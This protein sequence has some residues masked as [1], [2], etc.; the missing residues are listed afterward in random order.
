[1]QCATYLKKG[2]F[3]FRILLFRYMFT[4]LHSLVC[5]FLYVLCCNDRITKTVCVFLLSRRAH[6]RLCLERLKSLVPLGPD[7]NRHTT[8]SLLMKAKEHIAVCVGACL[9]L[10]Q[11]VCDGSSLISVKRVICLTAVEDKCVRLSVLRTND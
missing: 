7:A 9:Y 3:Y 8:L 4:A 6:L 11:Y 5:C 1:M 2:V 10:Y